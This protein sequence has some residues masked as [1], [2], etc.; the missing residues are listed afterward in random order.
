MFVCLACGGGKG[1]GTQQ[2]VASEHRLTRCTQ[3]AHGAHAARCAQDMMVYSLLKNVVYQFDING[4]PQGH[5]I[6]NYT[7]WITAKDDYAVQYGSQ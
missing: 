5:N 7:R 4:F 3:S 2:A 6:T 1:G